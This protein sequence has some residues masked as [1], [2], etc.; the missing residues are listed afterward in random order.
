MSSESNGIANMN[1]LSNGNLVSFNQF[2]EG[3]TG[4][5]HHVPY[6]RCSLYNNVANCWLIALPVASEKIA[7][8][9]GKRL[10]FQLILPM[11]KRQE[12]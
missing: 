12:L 11:D 9:A 3:L 4:T 6:E 8:P 5:M 2:G 10:T 1:C 7:H